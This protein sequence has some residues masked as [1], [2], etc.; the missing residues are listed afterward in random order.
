[1]NPK[2]MFMIATLAVALTL[3]SLGTSSDTRASAAA[4]LMNVA[5]RAEA[6]SPVASEDDFLQVLGASSDDDVYEQLQSGMSLAA[7]ADRNQSDVRQLIQLQTTQ[8]QQ[9]LQD[10][11]LQGQISFAEYESQLE[12]LESLLTESAHASYFAP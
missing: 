7:I 1:M 10:R 4:E 11:L 5:D 12:E 2:R 3:G 8:M 6:E 9:L